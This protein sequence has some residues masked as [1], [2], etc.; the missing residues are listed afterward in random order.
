MKI[1]I[2]KKEYCF[3]QKVNMTET[4]YTGEVCD[5][6]LCSQ[7]SEEKDQENEDQENEDQENEDQENADYLNEENFDFFVKKHLFDYRHEKD[8]LDSA[9]NTYKAADILIQLDDIEVDGVEDIVRKDKNNSKDKVLEIQSEIQ[10]E[11][12]EDKD[13]LLEAKVMDDFLSNELKKTTS[14][15]NITNSSFEKCMD[16][17]EIS[18]S[19]DALIDETQYIDDNKSS[20]NL[21]QT[22]IQDTEIQDNEYTSDVNNTSDVSNIT[23]EEHQSYIEDPLCSSEIFEF[24]HHKLECSESILNNEDTEVDEC[25]EE[26]EEDEDISIQDVDACSKNTILSINFISNFNKLILSLN[27]KYLEKLKII[28]KDSKKS[29]PFV[30]QFIAD[31]EYKCSCFKSIKTCIIKYHETDK[32]ETLGICYPCY[33]SHLLNYLFKNYLKLKEQYELELQDEIK[34][35]CKVFPKIDVDKIEYACKDD[36]STVCNYTKYC[37]NQQIGYNG[38]FG[39]LCIIHYI[40]RCLRYNLVP[41]FKFSEKKLLSSYEYLQSLLKTV[42]CDRNYFG[43]TNVKCKCIVSCPY[44]TCYKLEWNPKTKCVEQKIMKTCVKYNVI[45]LN[46]KILREI[47]KIEQMSSQ[48]RKQKYLKITK[49]LTTFKN[50]FSVYKN[51]GFYIR[52]VTYYNRLLSFIQKMKVKNT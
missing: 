38:K 51:Y 20:D 33:T 24:Q 45:Y 23:H 50:K 32:T 26:N 52:K 11:K 3:V 29:F 27:M 25:C 8:F 15:E 19:I 5:Q 7:K 9:D 34:L 1:S 10:S 4:V 21:S 36:K 17:D 2:D 47:E 49:C 42:G 14:L 28:F 37:V 46:N 44:N 18:P 41:T 12:L 48:T 6:L 43:E 13:V 30:G 16:I 35:L 39:S 22:E 31:T 40:K